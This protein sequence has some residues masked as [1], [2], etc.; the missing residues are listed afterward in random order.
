ML[1]QIDL[2]NRIEVKK[3]YPNTIKIKIYEEKA[4][5]TLNKKNSKFFVM[6]S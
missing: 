2:L 5:A 1:F 4:I 3:K 6:D